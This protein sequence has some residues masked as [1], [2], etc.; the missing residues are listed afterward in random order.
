MS[1]SLLLLLL[2]I[3]NGCATYTIGNSVKIT[4][5]QK[6]VI[7][8]GEQQSIKKIGGDGFDW[9]KSIVRDDNG[10]YKVFGHTHK[11]F[12]ESTDFFVSAY[13]YDDNL[14]WAKTYGGTHKEMPIKAI[15]VK[16]SGCILIGTSQSMFFTAMKVF[17]P[18]Y[19]PRPIIIKIDSEG[20]V[21][22]AFTID[23]QHSL[24]DIIELNDGGFLLTGAQ[25]NDK[26]YPYAIKLSIEGKKIWSYRYDSELTY[27]EGQSVIE[28]A[29]QSILIAGYTGQLDQPVIIKVDKA[30]DILWAKKYSVA[31]SYYPKF[32]IHGNPG[33]FIIS[34]LS[35]INDSED[36][37]FFVADILDNGQVRWFHIFSN[38]KN[39]RL[40]SIMKGFHNDY[41]LLG[42]TDKGVNNFVDGVALLIDNE[43]KLRSSTYIKGEQNNEVESAIKD[44]DDKYILVGSTDSYKATFADILLLR[45]QPDLSAQPD[46]A[47]ESINYKIGDVKITKAPLQVKLTDI[48]DYIAVKKIRKTLDSIRNP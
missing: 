22:W 45:W 41:L 31:G 4:Y 48:T 11:S 47:Q 14:K 1:K 6:R 24:S 34:G 27:C 40:R 26:G 10:D 39:N 29:D 33:E 42:D 35:K 2:F 23:S 5:L 38:K 44:K 32:L 21:D 18:Y 19:D 46:Y 37:G 9:G 30:G 17:A 16:D 15:H 12:G 28:L 7:T 8:T 13:T 25:L 20:A 3:T 43:G 36:K